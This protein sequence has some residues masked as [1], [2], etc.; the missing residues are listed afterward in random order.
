MTSQTPISQGPVPALLAGFRQYAPD[1]KWLHASKFVS[2]GHAHFIAH[3]QQREGTAKTAQNERH[4][5]ASAYACLVKNVFKTYHHVFEI[6]LQAYIEAGV[7]HSRN[8]WVTE[9]DVQAASNA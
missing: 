6:P 1:R 2:A 8:D 4:H 7:A 3:E 9:Q 5:S